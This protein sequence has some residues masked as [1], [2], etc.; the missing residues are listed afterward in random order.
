M[1]RGGSLGQVAARRTLRGGQEFEE[2]PPR[3]GEGKAVKSLPQTGEERGGAGGAT[4]GC[5]GA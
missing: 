3:T 2:M 5:C 1:A 4:K